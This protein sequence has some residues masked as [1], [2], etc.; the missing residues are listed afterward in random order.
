MLSSFLIIK[1]QKTLNYCRKGKLGGLVSLNVMKLCK[2][3]P[4][5]INAKSSFIEFSKRFFVLF[6]ITKSKKVFF[7]AK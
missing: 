7:F 5:I 4:S 6:F 2:V 1:I 3:V